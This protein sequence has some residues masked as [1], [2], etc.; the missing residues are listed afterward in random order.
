[1]CGSSASGSSRSSR[2]AGRGSCSAHACRKSARS[3]AV[4]YGHRTTTSKPPWHRSPAAAERA[5]TS[6]TRLESMSRCAIALPTAKFAWTTRTAGSATGV[7]TG[8]DSMLPTRRNRGMSGNG[9]AAVRELA[10]PPDG[11]A[12]RGA[13][14]AGG[15][16][17]R[18]TVADRRVRA[19]HAVPVVLARLRAVAAVPSRSRPRRAARSCAPCLGSPGTAAER[20]CRRR[21]AAPYARRATEPRLRSRPAARTSL[22][23]A[24]RSCRSTRDPHSVRGW[25]PDG[26]FRRTSGGLPIED[27]LPAPR[28]RN[29]SGNLSRR[30]ARPPTGSARTGGAGPSCPG[31]GRG[32]SG[33]CAARRRSP[34]RS[35]GPCSPWPRGAA[36][37]ARA[38]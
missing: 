26:A 2:T 38:C 33:P 32:G 17:G 16:A 20:G 22:L 30:R 18:R 24:A 29:L 31:C 4:R 7:A 13:P 9:A 35:G 14:R 12:A 36:P 6:A 25:R 11:E 8:M 28:A 3:P 21:S 27:R 34:R 19:D 23:R 5:G 15:L 37:R 10:P 1:M